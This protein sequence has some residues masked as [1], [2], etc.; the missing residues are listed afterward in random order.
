MQSL[1]VTRSEPR[2]H[3]GC[4]NISVEADWRTCSSSL[5]LSIPYSTVELMASKSGGVTWQHSQ[6]HH[7][8]Q[9]TLCVFPSTTQTLLTVLL[10][11]DKPSRGF[12]NS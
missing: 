12:E 8:P 2:I 10:V 6:A 7:H 3:L 1:P 9:P 11:S 5:P 4:V